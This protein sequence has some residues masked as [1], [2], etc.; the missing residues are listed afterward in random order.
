MDTQDSAQSS[1]NSTDTSQLLRELQALNLDRSPGSSHGSFGTGR[2]IPGTGDRD[3]PASGEATLTQLMMTMYSSAPKQ[4]IV[5]QGN[6]NQNSFSVYG[7]DVDVYLG[8]ARA[9]DSL[10]TTA[11]SNKVKITP[12]VNYDWEP[13]YYI[14]NLVAVHRDNDF[15]AY[16]LKGKSNGVVRV[17]TRKTAE[18]VLLK[19]FD[20]RVIDVAFAHTDEILLAA[21]DEIGNLFVHEIRE[22][23]G[24][25]VSHLLLHIKHPQATPSSEFHRVIWCP[26]I[27]ED[28]E[29]AMTDASSQ[30]ASRVLVLTHDAVAEIW[31]VD[32]VTKEHGCG[33]H[34]PNTIASGLI[35]I[36]SHSKPIVD[37]AFSPD[38]T[39]MA[40]ASLDGEVKFFQVYMQE[41]TSPRCL[42]Q[43]KP[44][45]GKPMSC[46]FFLDDHKNLSA[47]AQFWKY[48]V[49][50]ANQNQ[51]LKIWSCES[52]NCLQTIRFVNPPNMDGGPLAEVSLKAGLDLGAKY[53]V[54]SDRMRK[55]LYVLQVHQEGTST[56]AHVS[57]VSEFLLAQPCLSY[58]ILDAST[59]K[60]KK[61][62]ND[63]HLDEITT[64]DL[65]GDATDD[66]NRLHRPEETTTGVQLRLFAV[67]SKALQELL[68]R[69]KPESSV[70]P[71]S[72]PSV[73]SISHDETGLRDALSDIS[74]SVEQSL[75]ESHGS[76]SSALHDNS[77]PV[78][79]T[80]DAFTS[81]SPNNKTVSVQNSLDHVRGSGT[82][83]HMRGSG[84]S[85]SSFTHVTPMNDEIFTPRSSAS[86]DRTVMSPGSSIAH[87]PSS[88]GD[89]QSQDVT[90]T[91][92]PLPPIDSVEEEELATPK[93]GPE[94][95]KGD[96]HNH[97][98]QEVLDDF[99]TQ[100]GASIRSVDSASS[101][102]RFDVS[103]IVP[104][105]PGQPEVR[106][107]TDYDENDQE[108]AEVLG[109]SYVAVEEEGGE[110]EEFQEGETT[111]E[112][113]HVPRAWPKP[114]D[115]PGVNQ[116]LSSEAVVRDNSSREETQDDD[117]DDDEEEG[118]DGD[119]EAE[120]EE[121]IEVVEEGSEEEQQN[122]MSPRLAE[123]IGKVKQ[124][125]RSA[126]GSS[127]AVTAAVRAG[128]D[129]ESWREMQKNM[130][131]MTA[132]LQAQ[133][134]HI[135]EL[136]QQIARQHDQQL[137]LQQQ[138]EEQW[139]L[140]QVAA[141]QP[142]LQEQ[143]Q[144]IEDVMT[145]RIERV[146][147]QH[148]GRQTQTLQDVMTRTEGRHRQEQERL[149]TTVTQSV[150]QAITNNLERA[151][152]A[153]MKN[154]VVPTVTKILDPVKDQL[155]QD[156]AHK[157]TATDVLL[158]D[159]IAKMVRSRQTVEAIA[160]ATGSA[161]QA[162]IQAA[163]REAFQNMV[164]PS[165]ERASQSM[166]L[167]VNEAFQRGTTEYA[168]QLEGHLERIRQRHQESRDP[169][170]K[171]LQSL[172]DNFQVTS[173][174][175]K[176][177]ILNTLQSE[178][179][180]SLQNALANLQ[181]KTL[182]HVREAV[183]EEVSV[184]VREH[185][186]SLSDQLMNYVRSGAATP[187]Q[188]SPD[189]GHLQTLR[190]S[191]INAVRLGNINEAFQTA[192]SASNLELVMFTCENVN[193]SLVFGQDPCP[194]KQPVLLSLVNQLSAD[195][196]SH[197][198][199]KIKY[200]EEAVISLDPNHPL[201]AEHMHGVLN[202]LTQKLKLFMAQHPNDKLTRS[203]KMLAMASQ[204]LIT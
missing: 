71:P 118:D 177:E 64:G 139:R 115:V 200:L 156:L 77:N 42:H 90:P 98:A 172:V 37:A 129:R 91:N 6:D 142:G 137:E 76:N 8:E 124:S 41:G 21:V 70:P 72:T 39:A 108:V 188:I 152:R 126:Y 19:D 95:E 194:L 30:D 11:G 180:T 141:T 110:A 20:G 49:T 48:A 125:P 100:G 112:E 184:A 97:S 179:N 28:C 186:A 99:F 170:V 44:H 59:K 133:Q 158:K 105:Q 185:G 163:Y 69:Y 192:L 198:E 199:L 181:E 169:I 175:M 160:N 85:T 10:A 52:W 154:T 174:E 9:G 80:P 145:S 203:F 173:G 56:T 150:S 128:V 13:K 114:P 74:M 3:M 82:I 15:V 153:E 151:V 17:I 86:G 138:K 65:D 4:Q 123:R 135:T 178:L 164:V 79:L 22:E 147:T 87:T 161:I 111:G 113:L 157:L 104:P 88:K 106:H 187:V 92:M 168:G 130:Q 166:F 18:R 107:R 12:V 62:P 122:Q 40:T 196:T 36:N 43:W 165:F 50:G 103:E 94:S 109:E 57:S 32:M 33:P 134:M 143:M 171:Q 93:G 14:G 117:D 83:D 31:S 51:E 102:G 29:E 47:D 89:A 195:F 127:E 26:Y 16:V 204:S 101:T 131:D 155:H 63:S 146:L 182:N 162:P 136:Q 25:V 73:S 27:P 58:A 176:T 78:L 23:D 66:I 119:D 61:S 193:P 116:N 189:L 2:N 55:M 34:Y 38:G 120:I 148:L 159:N 183:K 149:Q 24:K 67:H 132:V 81:P 140:Q 191:V 201:T 53:L 96:A 167:Q 84:S 144:R 197:T 75:P 7:R 190:T 202:G 35:T 46:L 54:L 68:I 1:L 45:E 5:L 121:E 60:L